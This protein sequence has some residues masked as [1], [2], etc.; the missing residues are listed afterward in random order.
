MLYSLLFNKYCQIV[1][2]RQ[3]EVPSGYE[4]VVPTDQNTQ[5]PSLEETKRKKEIW[6]IKVPE[7]V[8]LVD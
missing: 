5:C 2:R 4:A 6:L 7:D 1:R 3:P 8:R